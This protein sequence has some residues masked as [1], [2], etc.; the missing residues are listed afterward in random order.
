MRFQPQF[1]SL[2]TRD[3]P[4]ALPVVNVMNFGAKGN[5]ITNDAP[6][7]QAAINSLAKTGGT[8]QIPSGTYELGASLQV[9]YSNI[10]LCGVGTT[11]PVLRLEAGV[12]Q[13][14]IDIPGL[15]VNAPGVTLVNDVVSNL[16]LNG[17][18]NPVNPAPNTGN[19]FGVF[20]NG[21]AGTALTGLN[22]ENWVYDG[23]E[24]GNGSYQPVTN[25]VV[26]GNVINNCGRNGIAVG[27]ANNVTI[28]GNTITNTPSTA[29][30]NRQYWGYGS[31]AA[32]DLEPEG[33]I[34]TPYVNGVVIT[35]NTMEIM[36][37]SWSSN[38]V[39][40][41]TYYGPVTNVT[42]SGNTLTSSKPTPKPRPTPKPM[43]EGEAK[44]VHVVAAKP[45]HEAKPKHE[46]KTRVNDKR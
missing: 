8:V 38:G 1:D 32:I 44:H 6:A 34:S 21:T 26:T 46:V 33:A 11:Q 31:G 45:R 24:I 43:L 39:N 17:N 23:I 14:A 20:L 3:V 35:G 30:V 7:I 25:P 41:C 10:T 22:I 19:Y 12:Y 37:N 15:P 5:G 40:W 29:K 9:N 13:D 27:F 16:T 18:S 2:E 4:S 28:K 36:P 42:I